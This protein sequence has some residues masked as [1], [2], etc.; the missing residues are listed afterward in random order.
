[1]IIVIAYLNDRKS[2]E[3]FNHLCRIHFYTSHLEEMYGITIL[4]ILK[5][6]SD[7]KL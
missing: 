7:C 1:M 2:K 4:L 5:M 6:K 3:G